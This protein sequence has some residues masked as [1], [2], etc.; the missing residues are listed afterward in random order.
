[1]RRLYSDLLGVTVHALDDLAAH[2]R[3]VTL[4]IQFEMTDAEF[5]ESERRWQQ[6]TADDER[7]SKRAAVFIVRLA[8]LAY[9]EG[10]VGVMG[11]IPMQRSHQRVELVEFERVV[12][13]NELRSYRLAPSSSSARSGTPRLQA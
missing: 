11:P 5:E 10:V 8:L 1:M 2:Y 9:R 7:R 13:A 4:H 3:N 6:R 12:L